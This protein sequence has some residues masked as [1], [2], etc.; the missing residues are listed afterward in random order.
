QRGMMR[1]ANKKSKA[2]SGPRV[3]PAHWRAPEVSTAP[4]VYSDNPTDWPV[5]PCWSTRVD[6]IGSQALFLSRERPQG[7]GLSILGATVNVT[8]GLTDAFGEHAVSK[9]RLEKMAA[10]L[11][12]PNARAY[13]VSSE[14]VAWRVRQAE[15]QTNAAGGTPPALQQWRPLLEGFD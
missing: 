11:S 14:Y 7:G 15:E 9:A 12:G 6:A 3:I 4:A 13:P 1:M 5:G 8:R 2:Q 10:T